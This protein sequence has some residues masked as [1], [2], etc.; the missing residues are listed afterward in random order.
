MRI[1]RRF[2]EWLLSLP[3]PAHFLAGTITFSLLFYLFD[4]AGRNHSAV[5]PQRDLVTGAALAATAT[6]AW[7]VRRGRYGGPQRLFDVST[8][9]RT[10]RLPL[11][12]DRLT[13]APLL[14]RKKRSYRRL[15]VII[16]VECAVGAGLLSWA[17]VNPENPRAL[18]LAA[19]A[20]V[21]VGIVGV[22]WARRY[23]ARIEQ[24]QRGL[25][26]LGD[27]EGA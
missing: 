22:A 13:W 9:V 2:R 14:E 27:P 19:G 16:A 15:Q 4:V 18:W 1:V 23:V 7:A 6:G 3:L 20:F 8:A 5:S 25:G 11:D 21:V 12:A 10:G 24:M 17:A 26:L